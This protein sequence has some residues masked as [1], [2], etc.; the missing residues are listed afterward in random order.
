MR[1]LEVSRLRAVVVALA[2]TLAKTE[3][4]GGVSGWG[5]FRGERM[6]WG[7]YTYPSSRRDK[8]RKAVHTSVTMPPIMNCF[9]PVARTAARNSGLS[10]AL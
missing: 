10:H 5:G 1:E 6:G 2:S 4:L 3:K 8:A 9:F 7:E